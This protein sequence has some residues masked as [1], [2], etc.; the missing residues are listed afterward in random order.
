MS[1]Y[2]MSPD[3]RQMITNSNNQTNFNNRNNFVRYCLCCPPWLFV[4]A[5]FRHLILLFPCIILTL[6]SRTSEQQII[7]REH[8]YI[9][10][11]L[12]LSGRLLF[13]FQ[14]QTWPNRV[15]KQ[16]LKAVGL[17]AVSSLALWGCFAGLICTHGYSYLQ[18]SKYAGGNGGVLFSP[19]FS[20][21]TA[22]KKPAV[23]F[24]YTSHTF[25][26]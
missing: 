10:Y 1:I 6:G 13:Q 7:I 24:I 22:W 15:G 3:A 9:C 2:P 16:A 5:S 17:V 8:W 26:V 11:P 23:F 20:S 19:S 18:Q 12:W 21:Y 4:E 14:V 25:S